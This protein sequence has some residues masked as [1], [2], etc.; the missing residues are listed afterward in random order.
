MRAVIF[1][2]DGTLTDSYEGIA[3]ST[4]YALE[5][6]GQTVPYDSLRCMI[7]PPLMESFQR[8]FGLSEKDAAQ[9]VNF[10][11]E[12]YTE[13]GIYENAV[14]EGIPHML[15]ALKMEGIEIHLATSKPEIFARKILSRFQ[16]LSYFDEV[17][18]ASMDGTIS[19]KIDVLRLALDKMQKRFG[20]QPSGREVVM[21]GDRFHDLEAANDL[22]IDAVG[23]A[24][25]YADPGELEACHPKA[26]VESVEELETYLLDECY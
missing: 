2:L 12:R 10:Y 16:I 7:G 6:F 20:Y 5:Q 18:G 4:Q 23:V 19:G 3:K 9:A 21:V 11:R 13:I 8:F 1:D 15:E 14:Y 24:Y 26:I 25:G 22:G 17:T